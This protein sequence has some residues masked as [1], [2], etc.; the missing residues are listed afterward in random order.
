M[1]LTYLGVTSQMKWPR[2][3]LPRLLS[4]HADH[5]LWV[6]PNIKKVLRIDGYSSMDDKVE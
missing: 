6:Q 5:I 3:R 1:D 2:R 4:L